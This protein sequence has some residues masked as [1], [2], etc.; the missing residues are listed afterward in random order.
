MHPYA[1]SDGPSIIRAEQ[2]KM[3]SEFIV[4]RFREEAREAKL[5]A[6]LVQ[7]QIDMLDAH[8]RK[9]GIHLRVVPPNV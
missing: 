3:I 6:D 1:K 7:K 9:E 2:E 8:A 5:K 4:E